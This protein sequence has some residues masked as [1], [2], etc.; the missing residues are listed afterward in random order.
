MA[1]ARDRTLR[2]IYGLIFRLSE[3]GSVA[4]VEVGVP[5][6]LDVLPKVALAIQAVLERSPTDGIR[7]Q[8]FVKRVLVLDELDGLAEWSDAC[9][10][11]GLDAQY[12]AA[13]DT[14]VGH[15]AATIV[16]EITHAWLASRGYKY[17]ESDRNRIEGICFRR[18]VSFAR[19]FPCTVEYVERCERQAREAANSSYFSQESFV[20]RGKERLVQL[21]FPRWLAEAISRGA[22]PRAR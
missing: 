22:A 14:E 5:P 10:T 13:S 20:A 2:L 18:E 1:A 15:L 7:L 11:I 19:R 17:R 6:G 21:G 4:G 16:H 9:R 8:R 3:K 12:V